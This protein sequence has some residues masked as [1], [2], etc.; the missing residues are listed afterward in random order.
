MLILVDQLQVQG[1]WQIIY[2]SLNSYCG[3]VSTHSMK[4][5]TRTQNPPSSQDEPT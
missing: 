5:I 4:I 2:T 1:L 3:V